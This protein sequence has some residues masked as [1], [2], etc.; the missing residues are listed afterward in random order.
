MRYNCGALKSAVFEGSTGGVSKGAWCRNYGVPGSVEL[1]SA[2]LALAKKAG[3]DVYDVRSF[4]WLAGYRDWRHFRDCTLVAAPLDVCHSIPIKAFN[5]QIVTRATCS[6]SAQQA[7]VNLR[8]WA[9][10][11]RG[12]VTPPTDCSSGSG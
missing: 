11:R 2:A 3:C 4:A 12:Y 1:D 10:E 6:N 7:G 5:G 9:N 8:A